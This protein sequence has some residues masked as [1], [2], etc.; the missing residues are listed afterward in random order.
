MICWRDTLQQFMKIVKVYHSPLYHSL[1]GTDYQRTSFIYTKA[2]LNS[3][4][5]G[6]YPANVDPNVAPSSLQRLIMS[7]L[8]L[9]LTMPLGC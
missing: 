9:R 2:P 4:A 3:V 5:I 8:E 1:A 7:Y 6:R